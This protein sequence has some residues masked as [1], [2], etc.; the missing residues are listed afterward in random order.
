MLLMTFQWETLGNKIEISTK[1][2]HLFSP[3]LVHPLPNVLFKSSIPS[4][5]EKTELSLGVF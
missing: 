1:S 3:F 5:I 4:L 2:L